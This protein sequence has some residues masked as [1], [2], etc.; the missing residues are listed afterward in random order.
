[1]RKR[2]LYLSEYLNRLN[3]NFQIRISYRT[4]A[5]DWY[6]VNANQAINDLKDR[7][8]YNYEIF[9]HKIEDGLIHIIL[10]VN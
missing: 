8:F 2:K 10:K 3:T 9:S 5:I 7:Y 4:L 1:M 6:Y